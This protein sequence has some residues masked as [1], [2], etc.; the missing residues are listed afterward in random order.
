MDVERV[1]SACCYHGTHLKTLASLA[2]LAVELKHGNRC[3]RHVVSGESS[4]KESQATG[5]PLLENSQAP[6]ATKPSFCCG[7]SAPGTPFRKE[8]QPTEFLAAVKDSAITWIDTPVADVKAQAGSIAAT[9][10]FDPSLVSVLL[11]SHYAAYEDRTTELG[12][13]LPA[14]RI[15]KFQV[16]ALPVIILIRKN[17]I[18][19]IHS[20]E[21][22]RLEKLTRY[23]EIFMRKI[24]VDLPVED[25]V[26]MVLV[27]IIDQINARNFEHLRYLEEQ[28]DE[29][30]RLLMDPK[31]PRARLGPEIYEMKHGLISYLNTMWATR[32]VLDSLRYGDAEA[33]SDNERLL[34]RIGVLAQNVQGQI[35]LAEHLSE[36]LASG[37]EVLQSIYNNQLQILNNRLALVMTFLTIVGTAVLVPNTLATI[38]SNS[39]FDMVGHDLWWYIPLLV[40]STVLATWLT[41]WW[42][43]SKGWL[44]KR[45][46]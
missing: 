29:L 2:G 44:P 16:E 39:A 12:L 7:I 35:G 26:T 14:I 38:F 33:I 43:K 34:E 24:P 1:N 9:L 8:G 40:G 32:D 5:K 20:P 25:K 45:V 19:T 15:D 31:T 23:A 37:L 6:G 27:R 42:I 3:W 41:W 10:G 11:E 30:N 17:L 28:G 36:V 13:M 22:K 4:I 21:V 18:F 46:D